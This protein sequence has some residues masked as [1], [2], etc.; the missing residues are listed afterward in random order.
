[1]SPYLARTEP[2]S[3]HEDPCR[4]VTIWQVLVGLLCVAI[5]FIVGRLSNKK[6][7]QDD[8]ASD[9]GGDRPEESAPSERAPSTSREGEP[10]HA[11]STDSPA[12]RLLAL[13]RYTWTVEHGREFYAT[14][15]VEQLKMILHKQDVR[16][17]SR[18]LKSELIDHLCLLCA[19]GLIPPADTTLN[20]RSALAI[21][22]QRPSSTKTA[23]KSDGNP[24]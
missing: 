19:A 13:E 2:G 23:R 11:N 10:G 21:L 20:D 12:L 24:E 7:R 3:L 1:M 14:H 22:R 8:R 17:S 6:T 16:T 18:Q 4:D 9:C 5:A 15:N